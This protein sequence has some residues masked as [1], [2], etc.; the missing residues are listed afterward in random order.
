MPKIKDKDLI[1]GKKN[2]NKSIHKYFSDKLNEGYDY[3][4]IEASI[5]SKYGISKATINRIMK[6]KI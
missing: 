3:N 1:E 4:F 5:V 6:G 2:R